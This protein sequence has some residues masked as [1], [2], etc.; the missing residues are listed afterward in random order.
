MPATDPAANPELQLKPAFVF[1]ASTGRTATVTANPGPQLRRPGFSQVT[2]SVSPALL[3]T[4]YSCYS[5]II[6]QPGAD[7]SCVPVPSTTSF[8]GSSSRL[9]L[10]RK[11]VVAEFADPSRPARRP[12]GR[13]ERQPE[14]FDGSSSDCAH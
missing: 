13:D 8:S 12:A 11:P 14:T 10:A 1:R 4:R 9:L 5:A 6:T 2:G 7:Q 3:R